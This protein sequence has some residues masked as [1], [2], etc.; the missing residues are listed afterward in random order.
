[1]TRRA[2][3]IREQMKD[4]RC[5]IA[6]DMDDVVASAREMTD[7]RVY[8][9]RYPWACLGAAAAVGFV[10]V[11]KRVEVTSPDIDT[12][13]ALAKQ[14]KLV[15]ETNPK[16]Q[17][18]SGLAGT[19]LGLVGNALLRAGVAYVGQQMGNFTGEQAA[20]VQ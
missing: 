17:A 15:V 13:L 5:E 16:A 11:P 10:V 1:M 19:M 6:E 20:D 12:L 7:W 4:V 18:K 8:V 9:K 14:N 2:D 3:S